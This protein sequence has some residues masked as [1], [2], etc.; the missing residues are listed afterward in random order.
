M[1]ISFFNLKT[2]IHTITRHNTHKRA[3]SHLT[4]ALSPAC[5]AHF[6]F[7]YQLSAMKKGQ[8]DLRK[9][10]DIIYNLIIWSRMNKTCVT[11]RTIPPLWRSF[12]ADG[13]EPSSETS[14]DAFSGA[15]DTSRAEKNTIWGYWRENLRATQVEVPRSSC[16][17]VQGGGGQGAGHHQG[18]QQ[19]W[20]KDPHLKIIMWS[21]SENET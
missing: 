16:L 1:I 18:H 20:Q 13:I 5:P 4:E 11:A 15:S 14:L 21:I 2:H 17:L 6:C 9:T 7:C 8:N 12:T 19:G 10:K 3:R